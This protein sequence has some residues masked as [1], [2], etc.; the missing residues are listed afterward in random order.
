[1]SK[2]DCRASLRLI[3]MTAAT[4]GSMNAWGQSLQFFVVIDGIPGESRDA[5]FPNSIEAST[6]S[7]GVASIPVQG[8]TFSDFSFAATL[9]KASPLLMVAAASGQLISSAVLNVVRNG[10][11]RQ[12]FL[13]YTLTNVTVTSHHPSGR[14]SGGPLTEEFTLS[15]GTITVEY[16]P[17]NPD[18]TLGD[19]ITRCWDVQNGQP[20]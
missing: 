6:Y 4:V 15:Y 3:I 19:P 20:C 8:A 1:M 11:Q 7:A 14:I 10:G 2:G 12:R 18:G 16:R 9:S 17:Q 5:L 13:T